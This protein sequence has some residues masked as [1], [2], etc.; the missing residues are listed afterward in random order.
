MRLDFLS[1]HMLGFTDAVLAFPTAIFTTLLGVA[2]VYWLLALIGLVDFDSGDLH[3]D[4]DITDPDLGS[5]V[6]IIVAF[7]LQGVPFSIVFSLVV[8]LSWTLSCLGAMW[9]LALLPVSIPVYV[10]GSLLALASVSLAV[11][12][13]A[14]IV[15]P[16][17]GLFVTHAAIHNAS[18]VGQHCKVLTQGVDEKMGRAEVLQRGASINIR[19]WAHVPNS[20][21][22]GSNA[23][24][25]AYDE[26]TARYQIK[27]DG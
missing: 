4:A 16:L 3:A 2:V 21:A 17:R 5:L 7:G 11:P 9:L 18:L 13:S 8:L 12:I 10:S 25:V 22:R 14:R 27:A 1:V 15:K 23:R 6:G 26:E 20:L 19:V 24:V